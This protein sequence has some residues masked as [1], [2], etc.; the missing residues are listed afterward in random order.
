MDGEEKLI[1]NLFGLISGTP[2]GRLLFVHIS[3][4]CGSFV[5]VVAFRKAGEKNQEVLELNQEASCCVS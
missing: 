3:Q 1:F 2:S 5:D 4:F